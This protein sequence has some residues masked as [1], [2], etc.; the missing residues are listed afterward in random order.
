MRSF[1][2]NFTSTRLAS[3]LI[4]LVALQILVSAVV[5]QRDVAGGQVIGWRMLPDWAGSVMDLLWLD[6]VYVSPI[7]LATLALL[8]V[9]LLVGNVRR[10]RTVAR[11]EGRLLRSRHVGS[12]VFHLALLIILT[13]IVLNGL[14]RFDGAF[15]VTEGQTVLDEPGA[16]LRVE[17]GILNRGPAGSFALTLE[18][19]DRDHPVGDATTEAAFVDVREIGDQEGVSGLVR[20]NHPFIWEG[21]EFHYGA[22]TGVSPE[23][24]V[25]DTAGETAF[26]SFVRLRVGESEG[27]KVHEGSVKLPLDGMEVL[28]RIMDRDMID[29]PA[30]DHVAVTRSGAV[31]FE[32]DLARGDTVGVADYHITMPR[33][34]AWCDVHVVR[35]PWLAM[36][37]TGFWVGLAGLLISIL[38]RVLGK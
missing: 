14:F 5:P 32:G 36:V 9:N 10:F 11:V 29:A 27:L 37:F 15:G 33:V 19:I 31:L 12:I 35:N 7:F 30:T 22:R 17:K 28:L 23:I 34:R 25:L 20:I 8:A 6:R 16:Y 13:G 26:R 4:G 3:W 18:R 2:V 24:L 1:R 21:V 38:P